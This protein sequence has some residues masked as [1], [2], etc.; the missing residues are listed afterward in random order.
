MGLSAG[1]GGSLW[2]TTLKGALGWG[3]VYQV[4]GSG[5]S[6]VHKFDAANAGSLGVIQAEDGRLYGAA[7]GLNTSFGRIY[8]LDPLSGAFNVIHCFDGND[9][10]G[11]VGV[12]IQG[13]DGMLYARRSTAAKRGAAF[14]AS[15]RIPGQSLHRSSSPSQSGCRLRRR[16]HARRQRRALRDVAPHQHAT[17]DSTGT[18]FYGVTCQGGTKDAGVVYRV[19]LHM[20]PKPASDSVF[21]FGTRMTTDPSCC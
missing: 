10:S 11:P 9:G 1:P 17:P 13:K 8:Q 4:V 6:I 14:I 7:T 5:V 2:G 3:T 16:L 20:Y 15:I 19:N 12:P 21:Q 18:D